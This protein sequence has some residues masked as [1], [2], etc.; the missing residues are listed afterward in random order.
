MPRSGA[1]GRVMGKGRRLFVWGVLALVHPGATLNAVA[2]AS[3]VLALSAPEL[4]AQF[5]RGPGDRGRFRD[6]PRW[7]F[8]A[9]GGYQWS[10]AVGDPETQT[11]WGFDSDWSMRLSAERSVAPGTTA[12]LVWNYSRMPL[13]ILG[14]NSTAV[15]RQGC[16]GEATIASY[17]VLLRS[18]GGPG[19]HLVY[20][21]FLGAMQY[22]NFSV[23]GDGAT[24]FAEVKDTDLA[25]GIGT[26]FGYGLSRDFVLT[27]MFEYGNS[28]HER[29]RDLFQ[30]RTTQH[31]TTR[32]GVRVGL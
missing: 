27:A 23:Q 30:R 25:W 1:F 11:T 16:E 32:V 17:G 14:T 9:W 13:T 19:L 4:S 28:V 21:G 26:G 22:G 8:S 31:Y 29:S 18:G 2:G 7:W 10:N 5:P 3:L 24:R 12:G 6:E 20:E 15:C